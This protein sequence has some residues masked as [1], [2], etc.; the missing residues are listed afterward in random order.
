MIARVIKYWVANDLIENGMEQIWTE[1]FF[2]QASIYIVCTIEKVLAK[3]ISLMIKL[4]SP[5]RV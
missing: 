1:I 4:R 2:P 3:L 5:I